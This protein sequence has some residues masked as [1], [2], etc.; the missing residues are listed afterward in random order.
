MANNLCTNSPE[1]ILDF[2]LDSMPLALSKVFTQVSIN[3][4]SLANLVQ[5]SQISPQLIELG[6]LSPVG[7]KD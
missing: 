1:Y 4:A 7:I 3:L 5:L 2:M 6:S